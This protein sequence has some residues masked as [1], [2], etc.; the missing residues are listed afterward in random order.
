MKK[1]LYIP[2][3]LFLLCIPLIVLAQEPEVYQIEMCDGVHLATD[4]Y[5]PS[6]ED[7]PWPVVLARTP[8]GRNRPAGVGSTLLWGDRKSELL[9]RGIAIVIQDTRG[10][11]DSE[12]ETLFGVSD[13][14]G[15][16]QDGYDTVA[17]IRQQEWCNGKIVTSGSSA[18]GIT[19]LLLAGT[20]PEGIAG[21]LI[22]TA[23]ASLYHDFY[24]TGG[25]FR[26]Q[27]IET[28]LEQNGF[29]A[30]SHLAQIRSH[31]YYDDFWR[32]MNLNERAD[33]V[34]CPVVIFACWYDFGLQSTLDLYTAIRD[35]SSHNARDNVFMLIGPYYHMNFDFW[36]NLSVGQLTFPENAHFPDAQ[37]GDF[38]PWIDHWLLNKTLEPKPPRVLYYMM[39][40]LPAG[41]G[42]GNEWRA[43]ADWPPPAK[44]TS[45]FLT[46]DNA[47]QTEPPEQ[48]GRLTYLYNPE[49][50]V[51]TLGGGNIF[52]EAGSYDQREIEDRGDV[53]VFNTAPVE[54]PIE[55]AGRLTAVVYVSTSA[56]DT[57]FTAKLT[58][59]YPD[60]RSMLICESIRRLS[61]REDFS[62]PKEVL[63]GEKYRLEIDL[64]STSIVFNK[65]HRL[66]LAISSS[67]SPRYEP[68]PNTG[69]LDW[70]STEK[71]I[72]EQT[73]YLGGTQASHL[74]LPIIMP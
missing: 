9:Q 27:L 23:P 36:Q 40:E 44:L 70:S 52:S 61:L 12:G 51:P 48:E 1:R 54:E 17:W 31:P 53:L 74:L 13:G 62:Q 66:R 11:H 69:N 19:Q 26:K 35:Q 49:N 50:P 29:P 8:Y 15:E 4:V 25:V 71:V 60:G 6:S 38:F 43:A 57:D 65:G 41:N 37:W 28:W 32:T 58:D 64:G 10:R 42:P 3:L 68:N 47:L 33:R 73:I 21:Q 34:N 22:H 24:Y 63:P 46:A 30:E 56:K 59:V 55:V 67:N 18:G 5:L 72:A 39:G 14:W 2:I 16:K 7:G 45:W 20:G